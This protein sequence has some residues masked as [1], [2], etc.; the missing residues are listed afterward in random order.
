[1]LPAPPF[2]EPD[3]LDEQPGSTIA[4]LRRAAI[5][6]PARILLTSA[7]SIINLLPHITERFLSELKACPAKDRNHIKLMDK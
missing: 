1:V 3:Q 2:F 5:L 7:E 6:K 4:E